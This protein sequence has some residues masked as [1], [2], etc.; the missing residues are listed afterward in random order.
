MNTIK[1]NTNYEE[2]IKNSKFISLLF[3]EELK[4]KTANEVP[5]LSNNSPVKENKTSKLKYLDSKYSL[6][7]MYNLISNREIPDDDEFYDIL[8]NWFD[9]YSEDNLFI[10]SFGEKFN[11]DEYQKIKNAFS[12]NTLKVLLVNVKKSW[13]IPVLDK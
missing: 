1:N 6:D 9:Y 5:K 7:D 3:K 13:F 12:D 10:N 2:I 8:L 11:K 4:L